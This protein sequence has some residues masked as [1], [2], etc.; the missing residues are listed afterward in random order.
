[1]Y[2]DNCGPY[3]ICPEFSQ[4]ISECTVY[5]LRRNIFEGLFFVFFTWQN[6]VEGE[7]PSGEVE[8]F[9]QDDEVGILF[10]SDTVAYIGVTPWYFG[11]IWNSVRS[12]SFI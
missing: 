9:L 10:S 2:I 3:L 5:T 11:S 4:H 7:T 6:T 12:D 8:N 1:M